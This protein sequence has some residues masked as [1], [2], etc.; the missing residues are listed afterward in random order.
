MKSI[1][2]LCTITA[3]FFAAFNL[4]ASAAGPKDSASKP[5]AEKQ[6]PTEGV[7]AAKPTE[8]TTLQDQ[9]H[10]AMEKTCKSFTGKFLV[11]ETAYAADGSHASITLKDENKKSAIKPFSV[12]ISKDY[13][14]KVKPA[15]HAT[16]TMS[17]DHLEISYM[18]GAERLYGQMIFDLSTIK[19]SASNIT[20]THDS[21]IT[22]ATK[23]AK[24]SS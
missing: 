19:S 3:L 15:T 20:S 22:A 13:A 24:A 14:M 23:P 16:V 11:I 12:A 21:G 5:T 4:P 8:V 9:L 2:N 6:K 7:A 17:G 10:L 1:R 18:K